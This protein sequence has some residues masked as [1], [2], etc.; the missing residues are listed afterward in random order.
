MVRTLLVMVVYAAGLP[1]AVEAEDYFRDHVAPVLQSR[2]LS[3]HNDA[4]RQGDFS[5]QTSEAAFADGHIEPGDGAA[6][7]LLE[8]ITPVDGQ[9]EMPQDGAPLSD[10]EVAAIR[11]WIEDG[12]SWPAG[13]ELE[14]PSVTD[15]GWWSLQPVVRP[16]LP[17]CAT[18][19]KSV[20][21]G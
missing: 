1:A 12:A 17:D 15:F 10:E 13:F 7:Y 9:A 6:S 20:R 2:C 4:D 19:R 16:P 21:Y 14:Q 5:L 8:L 18:I 3:C 11:Q